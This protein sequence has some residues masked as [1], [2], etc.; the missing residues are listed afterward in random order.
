VK[1]NIYAKE[2]GTGLLIL[3]TV[4]FMLLEAS[5]LPAKLQVAFDLTEEGEARLGRILRAVNRY[6]VIKS[7]A[8]LATALIILIWLWILGI[9]FVE[10]WAILAFLLNYIPFVGAILMMIPPVV[11]L[12]FRAGHQHPIRRFLQT[13]CLEC[14]HSMGLYSSLL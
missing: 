9:N 6:M 11:I 10:L 8:S 5:G 12:P 14:P 7:L 2:F 4:V 3:L 13:G 1:F